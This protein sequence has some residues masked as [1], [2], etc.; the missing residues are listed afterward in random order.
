MWTSG[1]VALWSQPRNPAALQLDAELALN[2]LHRVWT[3]VRR[4][5]RSWKLFDVFRVISFL[6]SEVFDC[7]G[8]VV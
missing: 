3:V 7:G 5:R 2:S 8:D 6:F 4:P 1:V